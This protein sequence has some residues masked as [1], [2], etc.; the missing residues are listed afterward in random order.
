MSKVNIGEDSGKVQV[1]PKITI[2]SDGD[3]FK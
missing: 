1:K 2:P 3:L